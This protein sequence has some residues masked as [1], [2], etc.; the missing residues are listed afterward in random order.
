MKELMLI[1]SGL[2]APK[3]QYNSFGKYKYRSCED[4]LKA[5]KPLL[6]RHGCTL[7]I[8][9]DIVPVQC[10]RIVES[11]DGGRV[12]EETRVYVKATATLE[13]AEGQTV[14]SVAFARE[15]YEK[16]GMDASQVTGA[17]S[18]YARKYA[19]NG[20]F[21]LD[22]TRDSDA[23]SPQAQATAAPAQTPPAAPPQEIED[24]AEMTRGDIA[25]APDKEAVK[26]I[27]AERAAT[28]RPYAALHAEIKR[29]VIEKGKSFG[30]S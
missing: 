27:W 14:R 11:R 17:A 13:N 23:L 15:E 6:L 7:V 4:I 9:D 3:G 8:T 26:R 21:C 22:D 25:I 1:Q 28:F 24:L 5:V 30:N 12:S 2:K 19:L 29:L 16:K 10:G 18:S 20:L